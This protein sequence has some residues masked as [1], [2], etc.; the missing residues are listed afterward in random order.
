[1][2]GRFKDLLIGLCGL[3]IALFGFIAV[4]QG[5]EAI[6]TRQFDLEWRSREGLYAGPAGRGGPVT[7]WTAARSEGVEHYRD[8][9]AIRMGVG[10]AAMGGL[11]LDWGLPLIL[12]SISPKLLGAGF[13][14]RK[15]T[16]VLLPVL[17][18]VTAAVCLWPPWRVAVDPAPTAFYCTVGVDLVVAWWIVSE[19]RQAAWLPPA[20]AVAALATGH[21]APGAGAGI[22]FG[23]LFS[24]I[25]AVHIYVLQV[26]RRTWRLRHWL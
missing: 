16:L 7:E 2:R 21:F 22:L 18:L 1:M 8:T 14:L 10:I 26:F 24:L 5:V 12:M 6:R 11:L 23:F 3:F 25:A 9:A 20:I 15:S 17:F 13:N 4:S 19:G